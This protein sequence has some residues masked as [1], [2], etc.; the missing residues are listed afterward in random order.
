MTGL[1]DE[2]EA[3]IPFLESHHCSAEPIRKAVAQMTTVS[4]DKDE[5]ERVARKLAMF[6]FDTYGD[7]EG[8][9]W[10]GLGDGD[11]DTARKAAEAAIA[12]MSPVDRLRELLRE[13]QNLILSRPIGA[14]VGRNGWKSWGAALAGLV[15]LHDRIDAALSLSPEPVG[16][17]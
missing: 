14:F 7:A 8:V 17:A 13:T 15:D 1:V 4:P 6:L 16:E 10:A 5:V 12:A 2:L 9:V 11:K 3:L